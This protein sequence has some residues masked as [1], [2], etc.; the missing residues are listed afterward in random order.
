MEHFGVK[1][2]QVSGMIPEKRSIT[3]ICRAVRVK[4][5]DC[6]LLNLKF[7]SLFSFTVLSWKRL[8]FRAFFHFLLKVT[9]SVTARLY[10]FANFFRQLCLINRKQEKVK[11]LKVGL[12]PK[13]SQDR[14]DKDISGYNADIR[15]RTIRFKSEAN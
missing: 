7:I 8:A 2:I 11:E 6:I 9:A 10:G 1:I 13:G 12:K 5:R 4:R 15:L 3:A 14:N